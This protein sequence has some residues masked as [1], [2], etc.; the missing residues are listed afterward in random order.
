MKALNRILIIFSLLV[1]IA[2]CTPETIQPPVVSEPVFT[3]NVSLNG[4]S[5]ELNAGMEDALMNT[6]ITNV[7]G[8]NKF[9]GK[10][11]NDESYVQIGIMEGNLDLVDQYSLENYTGSLNFIQ[12]LSNPVLELSKEDFENADLIS[13]IT[14]NVNGQY[15]ATNNLSIA[16]PGVY[17]ICAEVHFNQQVVR[18]ICNQVIVGYDTHANGKLH[19]V[20]GLDNELK[21]WIGSST[22]NVSAVEWS[23]DGE[24]VSNEKNLSYMLYSGQHEVQAEILFKNGAIRTKRILVDADNLGFFLSDFT[25]QEG[26]SGVVWDFAADLSIKHEGKTYHSIGADNSSSSVEVNSIEY[27]GKNPQGKEVYKCNA[28]IHAY[29]KEQGSGTVVPVVIHTV[30]GIPIE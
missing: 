3:A 20:M 11:G 4:E 1:A 16:E 6:F 29:V 18:T 27:Y 7:N 12:T 17:D 22:E 23:I 28:T 25:A 10:L 8:V 5:F 19:H 13:S 30:Y 15:A 21:A 2:S 26:N 14:W 24:L 9:T